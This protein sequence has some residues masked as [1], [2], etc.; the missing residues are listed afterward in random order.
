MI[1]TTDLEEL[2][3]GIWFEEYTGTII[4]G[5][6]RVSLTLS[7]DEMWDLCESIVEAKERLEKHPDVV[8]GTYI[9]AGQE[10]KSFIKKPDDNDLN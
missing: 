2:S 8:I 6:D 3:N 1:E 9:E 7:L 10:K 4:I 5:I